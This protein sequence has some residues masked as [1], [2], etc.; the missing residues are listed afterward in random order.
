MKNLYAPWRSPYAGAL[1]KTKQ[2]KKTK[3]GECV[4]CM[5]PQEKRDE[6]NFIIKRYKYCYAVLNKY[7]YNAGHLM[8]I[9]FAHVKDLQS[10]EQEAR[11]EIMEVVN[12]CIQIVYDELKCQGVNV[13]LNLGNAS[14]AGIP[15]HIHMHILPRLEGDTNFLPT[16]ANTKVISFDLKEIYELLKPAFK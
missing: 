10:L 4:F 15:S 2:E 3:S 1:T 8:V 7:P 5:Q 12:T 13:G 9:P 11:H 16:L 14:G 6:K